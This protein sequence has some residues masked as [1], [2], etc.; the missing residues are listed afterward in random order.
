MQFTHFNSLASF[1]PF[2]FATF[3]TISTV[4]DHHHPSLS[5]SFRFFYTPFHVTDDP[6]HFH[7]SNFLLQLSLLTTHSGCCTP[8]TFQFTFTLAFSIANSLYFHLP[9]MVS[10]IPS[11]LLIV[12]SFYF[13]YFTLGS[14]QFDPFNSG[15]LTFSSP[16]LSLCSSMS[17][18]LSQLLLQ[19][20]FHLLALRFAVHVITA[21]PVVHCW[22]N[23]VC[24]LCLSLS[25]RL[26][27]L[28][29][30][31]WCLLRCFC[32]FC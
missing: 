11:F 28:A 13:S 24:L 5:A 3:S 29:W 26:A 6:I 21:I 14:D 15:Y 32:G 8:Y 19:L 9:N 12:F 7:F 2:F 4:T 23:L 18:W 25:L 20:R 1:Y 31:P 30:L 22:C 17:S 10:K 27:L 16:W